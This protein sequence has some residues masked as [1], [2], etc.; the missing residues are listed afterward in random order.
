V[1]NIKIDNPILHLSL[2]MAMDK[3][4]QLQV[5]LASHAPAR[6][7]TRKQRATARSTTCMQRLQTWPRRPPDSLDHKN[8]TPIENLRHVKDARLYM[9]LSPLRAHYVR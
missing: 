1:K 4:S 8:P 7:E 6:A 3:A 2:D 9:A 5:Q